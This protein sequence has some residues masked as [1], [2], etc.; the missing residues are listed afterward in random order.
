MKNVH[1]EHPL[2]NLRIYWIDRI[3][4]EVVLIDRFTGEIIELPLTQSTYELLQYL[5]V[6]NPDEK[7][8]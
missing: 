7:P 1:I 2:S 8:S 5:V 6:Y 4:Q 3:K